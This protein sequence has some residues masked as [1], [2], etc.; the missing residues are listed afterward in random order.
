MVRARNTRAEARIE[1]KPAVA[2]SVAVETVAEDRA[3]G[4]R[5]LRFMALIWGIPIV[6]LL[7]S[8]VVRRFL[9]GG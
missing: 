8:I 7:L 9:V 2:P 4:Q 3:L 5:P 6:V 1:R